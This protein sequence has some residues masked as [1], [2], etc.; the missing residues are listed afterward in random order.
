LRQ[1]TKCR[2]CGARP[3][4]ERTR[5]DWFAFVL[6]HPEPTLCPARFRLETYQHTKEACIRDWNQYN[7]K[8][9]PDG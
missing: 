7:R 5:G 1:P 2:N 9:K 6:Q 3:G 4:V 8:D